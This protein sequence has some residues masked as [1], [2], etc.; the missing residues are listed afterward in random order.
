MVSGRRVHDINAGSEA[1][2]HRRN[3]HELKQYLTLKPCNKL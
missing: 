1:I 3:E 2:L